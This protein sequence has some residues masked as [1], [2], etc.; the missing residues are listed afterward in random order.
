MAAVD[1][2]AWAGHLRL[3]AA[4]SVE[5][6]IHR[7]T[8]RSAERRPRDVL[9]PL[10]AHVL[11]EVLT[12]PVGA[13]A[14]RDDAALWW[15]LIDH[16]SAGQDIIASMLQE[17]AVSSKGPI[18]EQDDYLALEVWTETELASL[19]AMWHHAAKAPS[20]AI[21]SR[22]SRAVDWHL[23]NTQPDN[24]TN[25]PWGIVAFLTH[26]S[27]EGVQLAQTVLNNCRVA[28]ARPDVMSAWILLDAANALDMQISAAP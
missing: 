9:L 3:V 4:D 18:I 13:Y 27:A 21:R 8:V 15:G 24:A 16:T 26:G 1:L 19:Q 22:L 6:E 25:R 7:I 2:K 5:P 28:N 11:G 20:R 23:E 10:Q 14:R 12:S 17:I